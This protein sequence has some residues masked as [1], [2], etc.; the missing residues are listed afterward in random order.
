[1]KDEALA[2][3]KIFKDQVETETEYKVKVLRTDR[4][5]EFNSQ[6]FVKFCQGEGN[7][8]MNLPGSLWVEAVRHAVYLLNRLPTKAV[9]YITPYKGWKKRKPNL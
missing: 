9:R 2:K 8:S 6:A 3:F 4:G 7:Q 5:V 1:S